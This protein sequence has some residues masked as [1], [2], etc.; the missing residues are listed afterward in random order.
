[1]VRPCGGDIKAH[2]DNGIP[3]ALRAS[4]VGDSSL[5]RGSLLFAIIAFYGI[6]I[7]KAITNL[8]IKNL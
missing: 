1:M 8:W 2:A 3:P 4:R 5:K 6:E 7:D